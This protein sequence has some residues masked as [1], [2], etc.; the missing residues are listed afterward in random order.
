MGTWVLIN[1]TWY[2]CFPL[3]HRAGNVRDVVNSTVQIG[4]DFRGDC[5]RSTSNRVAWKRGISEVKVENSGVSGNGNNAQTDQAY[6][7]NN[8]FFMTSPS[9]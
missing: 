3:G 9:R 7:G 5:E 1:E 2:K 4:C 8:K 6:G